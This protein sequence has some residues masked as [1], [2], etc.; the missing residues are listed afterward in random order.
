MRGYL[1]RTGLAMVAGLALALSLVGLSGAT[2][3]MSWPLGRSAV[4]QQHLGPFQVQIER[5]QIIRREG[6]RRTAVVQVHL[7]RPGGPV[8]MSKRLRIDGG[9]SLAGGWVLQQRVWLIRN[10]LMQRPAGATYMHPSLGA[11]PA[12]HHAGEARGIFEFDWLCPVVKPSA[13]G[14]FTLRLADGRECTF[15]NV[16]ETP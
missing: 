13:T 3:G 4:M 14:R 2:R 12:T 6:G 16:R 15:T 7:W 1:S 10:E 9:A 8:P 11:V 5:F